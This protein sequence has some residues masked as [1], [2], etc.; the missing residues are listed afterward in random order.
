[1]RM[2][3]EGDSSSFEGKLP[4]FSLCSPHCAL[5][6][7]A[8]HC[9]VVQFQLQASNLSDNVKLSCLVDFTLDKYILQIGKNIS[10]FTFCRFYPLT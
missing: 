10:Y 4:V 5:A 9:F 8:L 2:W 6:A 1:M 3:L 7:Y